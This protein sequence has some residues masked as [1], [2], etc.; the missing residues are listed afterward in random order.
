MNGITWQSVPLWPFKGCQVSHWA[1][2]RCVATWG[3]GPAALRCL[4][5]SWFSLR[6][7][8]D[9]RADSAAAV[10]LITDSCCS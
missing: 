5:L 3:P 10:T 6:E 4:G 1:L 9:V 7:W 2:T 8:L